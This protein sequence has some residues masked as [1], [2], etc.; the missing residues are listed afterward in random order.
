MLYSHGTLATGGSDGTVA[1]WDH[2]AKKR[3]RLYPRFPTAVSA[4]AFSADGTRLAIGVS[5]TH[6]DNNKNATSDDPMTKR[7]LELLQERKEDANYV[8][9]IV[10]TVGDELKVR[11]VSFIVL[12]VIVNLNSVP[13]TISYG[14]PIPK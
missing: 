2:R 6:E 9:I 3:L 7:K 11:F 13:P 4:L 10:R 1:V 8:G 12:R 5:T 14:L